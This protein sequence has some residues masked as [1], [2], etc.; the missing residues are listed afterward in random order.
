[1][2]MCLDYFLIILLL[3]SIMKFLE[4]KY[5][6]YWSAWEPNCCSKIAVQN[7][8]AKRNF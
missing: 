6:N 3:F 4:N 7:L 1:M 8:Q 5:W 2:Y